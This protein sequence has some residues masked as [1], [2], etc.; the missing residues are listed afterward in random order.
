M[1]QVRFLPIFI[2]FILQCSNVFGQSTEYRKVSAEELNLISD[3][4]KTL[5]STYAIIYPFIESVIDLSQ[6]EIDSL[7][8][9]Y[10]FTKVQLSLKVAGKIS[11]KGNGHFQ[12][13]DVDSIL[14]FRNWRTGKNEKGKVIL[15]PFLYHIRK[16]YNK[17]SVRYFNR[18][19]VS[20]NGE[21]AIVN[22]DDY[23][24]FLCSYGQLVLLQQRNGKW[25]IVKVLHVG[26]S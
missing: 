4:N 15:E 17:S 25:S 6:R 22:Y 1:V 26:M 19:I 3:L 10:G 12:V 14:K 11:L 23:C 2:L 18:P 21:Y 20:Q 13:I 9:N 16:I 24:G 8:T 7:S 5:D